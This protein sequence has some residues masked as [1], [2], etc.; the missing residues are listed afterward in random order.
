MTSFWNIPNVQEIK[1]P[2]SLLREQSSILYEQTEGRLIGET[3]A[4]GTGDNI[5]ID[6]KIIVPALNKY[7]YTVLQYKQ[8][9]ILLY[10]GKLISN[11]HRE[12]YEINSEENFI[13]ALKYILSSKEMKTLLLSLLSQAKT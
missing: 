12:S 5:I 8:Q 3:Q 2:L 4:V 9:A 1:T 13:E 10:P 7:T 11:L 6:L